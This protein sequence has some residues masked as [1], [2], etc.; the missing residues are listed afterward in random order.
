VIRREAERLRLDW[1][2]LRRD[3][4]DNA[5]MQRIDRNLQLARALDIQGTPAIL[6]GTTMIPGATDLATLR[7]MTARLRG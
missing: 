4:D 6:G 1:A 2:R 5:V 7:Q 3:M